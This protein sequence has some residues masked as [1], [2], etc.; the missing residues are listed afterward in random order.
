MILNWQ[1]LLD[2]LY[3][4]ASVFNDD[5]FL[6]VGFIYFPIPVSHIV[7]FVYISLCSIFFYCKQV[8]IH[9]FYTWITDREREYERWSQ[10]RFQHQKGGVLYGWFKGALT[11]NKPWTIAHTELSLWSQLIFCVLKTKLIS[12]SSLFIL[13]TWWVCHEQTITRF[14]YKFKS[15]QSL[16]K[17]YRRGWVKERTF[18]RSSHFTLWKSVIIVHKTLYYWYFRMFFYE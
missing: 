6:F 15:D 3:R 16:I 1:F 18:H 5:R 4:W 17:V 8:T 9:I 14:R 10:A 12:K 13:K 11:I 7:L 2:F